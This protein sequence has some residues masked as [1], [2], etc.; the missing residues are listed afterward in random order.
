MSIVTLLSVSLMMASASFASI[1][2]SNKDISSIIERQREIAEQV[3]RSPKRMTE[4][5]RRLVSEEQAKIYAIVEGKT[6][7]EELNQEQKVRLVN[8]IEKI[9]AIVEGTAAAE[10]NRMV[11]R[12]ERTIGSNRS[13]TRCVA[14]KQREEESKNA[15]NVMEQG[16]ACVSDSCRSF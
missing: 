16:E 6:S 14:K 3:Q 15:R 4:Q 13:A 1:V 5:Q 11:C 7:F 9:D 10:D 2:E 12:R 8:A